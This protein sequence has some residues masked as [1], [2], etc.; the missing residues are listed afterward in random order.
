MVSKTLIGY[1]KILPDYILHKDKI[2]FITATRLEPLQVTGKQNVYEL[3]DTELYYDQYYIIFIETYEGHPI[4]S[5]R[6]TWENVEKVLVRKRLFN[7]QLLV[8]G[9]DL[10]EEL[11]INYVTNKTLLDDFLMQSEVYLKLKVVK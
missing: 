9:K 2:K 8:K 11:L 4:L 5:K 6:I 1:E 7:T 3:V 10:T